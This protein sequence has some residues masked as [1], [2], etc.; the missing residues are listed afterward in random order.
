MS[1]LEIC[2]EGVGFWAPGYPDWNAA[3]AGLRESAAADPAT[4]AKPSP[5][6]LPPAERRRAPQPV[7]LACEVAAQACAASGHAPDSLASVFASTHGD[8]II[9]DYMCSTLVSAPRE[10]SPIRFHNSVHNA[11]AGYWTIAAHCH[12]ASTSVSSWHASFATALFEAAVEACAEDTPVLLVAYDTESTGP[13]LAV[14]PATSIFGVALVVAPAGTRQPT[15]RLVLRGE[16]S[17]AALPDGLPADLAAL[18]A[19]N[20]MAAGALPLLAALAAGG[21]S[22]LSLAAGQPG[23]LDVEVDA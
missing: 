13:L 10:L 9:T 22:R 7:L 11:P 12:L 2:I 8:L 18:A 3:L 16:A 21:R 17:D 23:T 14:S 1:A 5:A 19:G 20:P 15:L 4:P 6:L